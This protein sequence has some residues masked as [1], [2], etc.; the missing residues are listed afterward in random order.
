MTIASAPVSQR[1]RLA[2]LDRIVRGEW[3]E[4]APLPSEAAMCREFGTSRGS[5]RRA[6]ASLRAEGAIVGGRGRAP[7]V[8]RVVPSRPLLDARSFTEWA[9]DEG[10][11]AGQRTLSLDRRPATSH[12]AG[13]LGLD[14]GATV[15]ELVRV[16]TL[17]D[18]PVLLERAVFPPDVGRHLFG[19]DPVAGSVTAELARRGAAQVRSQHTVDAVG[20]NRL[21]AETLA[22][23]VGTPL[24]R[25]RR[26]A[27]DASGRTTTVVDA[28]YRPD[29]ATLRA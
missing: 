6:L 27:Q 9:R 20:A 14:E 4:G 28:R 8:G 18:V 12:A 19:L 24:L 11:T 25:D 13:A 23:P 29:F 7:V 15:V 1:V 26:R 10:R 3:A 21:D 2:V 22:V 5:V 16:R 17:D